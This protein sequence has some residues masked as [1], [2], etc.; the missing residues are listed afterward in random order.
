MSE[1]EK[2][3]ARLAEVLEELRELESPEKSSWGLASEA[4]R[5]LTVEWNELVAA[6]SE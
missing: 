2:S 4:Y 6:V 5:R 1:V 3:S